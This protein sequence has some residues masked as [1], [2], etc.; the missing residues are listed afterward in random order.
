MDKQR[1]WPRMKT[2]FIGDLYF[3]TNHRCSFDKK[4]S[5]KSPG[6]TAGVK[7]E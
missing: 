3:F 7:S 1:R 4:Y 2:D 5:K 6:S